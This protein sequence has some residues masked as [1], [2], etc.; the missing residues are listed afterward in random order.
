MD[1]EAIL[2]SVSKT[3]RLMILHEDSKT[4]GPGAEIAA[5]IAERAIY[6]LEAPI[7]RV[8]APDQPVPYSPPLEWAHLPKA[9]DVVEATK[10][11]IGR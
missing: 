4:G 11:L 6:E 2:A 5:R 1:E 10:D 8:A 7:V 3:H 9:A